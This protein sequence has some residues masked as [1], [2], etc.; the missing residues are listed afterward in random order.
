MLSLFS[1]VYAEGR[2]LLIIRFIS[3]DIG[4]DV[5]FNIT[6]ALINIPSPFAPVAPVGP[7]HP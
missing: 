6:L 2:L 7:V 5:S 1:A 4:L 3:G